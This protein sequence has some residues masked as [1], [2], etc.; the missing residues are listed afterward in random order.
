MNAI[1][2]IKFYTAAD[3]TTVTG[4]VTYIEDSSGNGGGGKQD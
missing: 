3:A 2:S 4:T 1:E